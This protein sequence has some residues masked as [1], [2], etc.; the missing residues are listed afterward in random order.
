[1][2]T[3]EQFLRVQWYL[4]CMSDEKL[5]PNVLK[6]IAL[7]WRKKGVVGKVAGTDEVLDIADSYCLKTRET[8]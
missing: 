3:K 6:D 2:N 8:W 4:A 7:K 5:K 1:M